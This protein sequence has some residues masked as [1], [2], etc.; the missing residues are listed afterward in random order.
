MR[1]INCFGALNLVTNHP[2]S[3]NC[4]QQITARSDSEYSMV[5]L[6]N[7]ILETG[8]FSLERML[9]VAENTGASMLY[10]D[11]YE[12]KEGVRKNHPVIDYQEGSLRDDFNF[13]PVQL[14]RSECIRM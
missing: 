5:S 2:Y 11:Y 6:E 8:Q 12:V 13:G 10:S 14:F 3:A 7:E 9:Q 1:N 4:I